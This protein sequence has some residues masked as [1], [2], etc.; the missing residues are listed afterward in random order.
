ML[1]RKRQANAVEILLLN[2]TPHPFGGVFLL[3]RPQAVLA[4][5]ARCLFLLRV[6]AVHVIRPQSD[7][8]ISAQDRPGQVQPTA[9]PDDA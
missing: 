7:E 6:G 2:Q 9:H 8:A 1:I 3:V 4:H 5:E